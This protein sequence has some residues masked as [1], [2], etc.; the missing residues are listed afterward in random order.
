MPTK[1][2]RVRV[3]D[4][5][6]QEFGLWQVL[7]PV[8]GQPEMWLCQCACGQRIHAL[9]Q[10]ALLEGGA[11]SCGCERKPRRQNDLSGQRF[12]ALIV[13]KNAG[14][15][16]MGVRTRKTYL[17]R[18]V[19]GTE[20]VLSQAALVGKSAVRSCGCRQQAWHQSVTVSRWYGNLFVLRPVTPPPSIV[21]RNN[22]Y[23]LCRCLCGRER[24]VNASNLQR[25]NTA[26][27]R[28]RRS[29]PMIG[30]TFGRLTVL[31]PS[32]RVHP[33]GNRSWLCVCTCGTEL[34]VLHSYLCRGHTA[35]CGCLKRGLAAQFGRPRFG[36]LNHNAKRVIIDA[37]AYGTL[38]EAAKHY[39]VSYKRMRSW[40]KSGRA[41]YAG[42]LVEGK[43][44][45][46]TASTA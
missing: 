11:R 46:Q 10:D 17:C 40:L 16:K 34:D 28:C 37:T 24:C 30:A 12:G 3:L 36:A 13:M 8:P 31:R 20:K 35:S 38:T 21:R 22:R 42:S 2:G 45:A 1:K 19:C 14:S 15:Q 4:L 27:C 5:R 6:F 7:G 43:E 29:S 44:P 23:F 25:G 39:G 33:G 41:Q 26:S 32:D 9:H 18:C